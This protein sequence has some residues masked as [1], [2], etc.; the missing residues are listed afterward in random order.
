MIASCMRYCTFEPARDRRRRTA[1]TSRSSRLTPK[2]CRTA[3][4]GHDRRR[5]L[6]VIAGQHDAADRSSGIQQPG[7]VLWHASSIT[8]RSNVPLAEHLAVQARRRRAQDGRAVEDA[9]DRL[10]LQPARVGEQRAG[11]LAHVAACARL[12][13][14]PRALAGLAE[15]GERLLG[16]LAGQ[17]RVVVVL[18]HQ[19]ERVLAQR[20]Q[21]AGGMAE[22]H[23]A[24]AGRQQPFEQVVDRQIAR[25]AGQH[26]ARRG[27]RPGGSARPRWSS[28]RCRAGRG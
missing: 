13:L 15:E 19:V 25:G 20:R 12:R 23:G 7:S 2:P 18:H 4:C 22:P 26:L 3:S 28:C 9:L 5:Q 21:D 10:A 14:G 27:A 16:Q 1:P 24:F 6:A 8:A 17:P 11:L